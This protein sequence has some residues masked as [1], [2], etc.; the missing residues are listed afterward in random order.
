[1]GFLI[2]KLHRQLEHLSQNVDE[3][4]SSF[5]VYRGQGLSY[6]DY[7]KLK[8]AANEA[9]LAFN[10]FL[11]ANTN[12]EAAANNA[13]QAVRNGFETAVLFSITIESSNDVS[14]PFACIDDHG[15]FENTENEYIF[16]INTVFRIEK[17]EKLAGSTNM[18]QL[19]K[20]MI[21]MKQYSTAEAI[22]SR[23]LN[24]TQETELASIE[25]IHYQLAVIRENTDNI[26]G[27]FSAY[28]HALEIAMQHRQAND[29]IIPLFLSK[30]A[31]LLKRQEKFDAA[32]E[33]YQEALQL[34]LQISEPNYR[35][36][37]KLYNDIGVV[38]A[39]Q[40]KYNESLQYQE[41]S[42]AI[43]FDQM[44]LD[45][46]N[47]AISYENMVSVH[48]K[49]QNYVMAL[50]CCEKALFHRQQVNSKQWTVIL[51][52]HYISALMLKELN[53]IDEVV[54]HTHVFHYDE[55]AAQ[56]RRNCDRTVTR[57]C[58]KLRRSYAQ[59]R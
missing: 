56:L 46:I 18:F 21:L 39:A 7:E 1:M 9:L 2:Q 20:L 19:A 36:R 32:L 38:L 44:P 40:E 42:L 45:H 4:T 26:S 11:S 54:Q 58:G 16:S 57:N 53:R 17:V 8:N 29:S 3:V 41:Q 55:T 10:T 13:R 28:E 35:Q 47:I 22:Y 6:D 15:Y 30:I 43:D 12:H 23:L 5:I 37:S 27:A 48:Q 25:N 34:D 24:E 52:D 59:L 33:K 49:M 14:I 51:H 31:N 50:L